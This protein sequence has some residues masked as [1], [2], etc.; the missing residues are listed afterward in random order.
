MSSNERNIINRY[1]DGSREE[2]RSS[3]NRAD[4]NIEFKYTKRILDRY[5]DKSSNVIEIGCGTGYYGMYLADK[6]NKYI[7]YDIVPG[8]IDLFNKKIRDNNI[9]NVE[10]Y[11]GDAINLTNVKDNS[12]DVVLVLGPMYHLPL[13]ERKLVFA[14]SKRVCKKNR[15]IMYAYINKIGVYIGSCINNADTYPNLQKNNSILKNGIDDTRDNIYWFTMPEDMEN[16]AKLNELI[17]LENLGIDF[18]FIPQI[19]DEKSERKEAF[20]ELLDFLTSRKSCTGFSGH[21]VMV[22]KNA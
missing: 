20:E 6:C 3:G 9:H 22:C 14:E 13:E 12:F 5:I 1:K 11:V 2:G 21:A 10:A 18:T 4:Y 17:V 15:I 16:E 19:L 7:G 8:N